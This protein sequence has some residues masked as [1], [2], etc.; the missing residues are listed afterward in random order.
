M[1][2][3]FVTTVLCCASLCACVAPAHAAQDRFLARDGRAEATIVIRQQA[4]SFERRIAGEMRCYLQQ[5]TGAELRVVSTDQAPADKPLLLLGGPRTNPLVAAAQKQELV[6]F[7]GLKPEGLVLKT[8]ERGGQTAI[9]VGGN[10]DSGTM[11]ACYEFLE[12]MGIVFQLSGDIIPQRKPDLRLPAL[13]VRMEPVQQHR[14][15]LC[16][17]G[18]MWY[19]GLDDYRRQIDQMAKLKLNCLQFL[20]TMGSPWLEF[21]YRGK[22]AEI[23]LSKESGY[24]AWSGNSAHVTSGTRQD[25]RVGRECFPYERLCGAEFRDVQTL[26]QAFKTAREFLRQVIRYAHERKVQVWLVLAEL[27]HV[28]SAF[29]PSDVARQP[30]GYYCGQAIPIG[31]P[32]LTDIWVAG[33]Q[34]M[35]E[36]CPDADNY[37][38]WTSEL[39]YPT[40]DPQT[41]QL[42][43]QYAHVRELIPS[44]EEIQRRREAMYNGGEDRV[45]CDLAQICVAAKVVQMVRHRYPAARLGVA[46]LFRSYLLRALDSLLPK[47]VLLMSMENWTNTAPIIDNYGTAPGRELVVMPRIDDDGGELHMQLNATMYDQDEIITGSAKHHVAGIIGQL[48]KQRGL[49]C[50][51]RFIADGAWNPQ[52]NCRRF[53]EGYLPR[54]FG[55]PAARAGVLRA[56]L[57]LEDLEKRLGWHGRDFLF[58][59]FSRFSPLYDLRMRTNELVSEQTSTPRQELEREIVVAT[60]R[61]RRSSD[62][63]TGYREAAGLLRRARPKVLPGAQA[64]LD[65]AIFKTETFAGYLDLRAVGCD[66]VAALDLALLAKMSGDKAESLSKLGE[67]HNA[68]NRADQLARKIARQM[69]PFADIPTEKYLLFRFNQNVVGWTEMCRA[70]L[71]K[72]PGSH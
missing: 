42:L 28:P 33:V 24:V 37:A 53:Y 45:E 12:L 54:V 7:A 60:Q 22:K 72:L 17:H 23:L 20:V 2:R 67:A 51:V 59:G 4:G 34:G 3:C 61:R 32:E 70:E 15:L 69:I 64:E 39:F 56:Y 49:E 14:G 44:L 35:I 5:L 62:L 41:R 63:A 55:G 10:D 21:S 25:I 18:V 19:A 43:R 27:P 36:N 29:V 58:L 16:N 46:V 9:V 26:D 66:A 57:I 48:N 50:N 38:I 65:Y 40:D 6:D 68:M 47:D 1:S 11:Y 30:E 31:H 8:I 71:S 52:I 13:D